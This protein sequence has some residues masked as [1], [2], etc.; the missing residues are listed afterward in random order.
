[1]LIMSYKILYEIMGHL[2][3]S[4]C[5]LVLFQ[6]LGFSTDGFFDISYCLAYGARSAI[7]AA[8]SVLAP[9]RK[10]LLLTLG[11]EMEK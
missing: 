6:W 8:V 10:K 3:F 7:A 2:L 4:A 9:A 1:M 11:L 5:F